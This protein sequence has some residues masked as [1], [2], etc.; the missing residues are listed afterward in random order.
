MYH[1]L[2][3]HVYHIHN[4]MVMIECRDNYQHHVPG[5]KCNT[6]SVS[7]VHGDA[8]SALIANVLLYQHNALYLCAKII[9]AQLGLPY[10]P[11]AN[12][13]KDCAFNDKSMNYSTQLGDTIRMIF[14]YRDIAYWS[15]GKNGY[16][17]LK[18]GC[19]YHG[20]SDLH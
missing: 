18:N 2:S 9:P 16:R 7:G 8:L 19:H 6:V 11:P 20:S 1:T 17:F 4:I 12:M 10:H 14:G 3:Y 15:R 5:K 13:C